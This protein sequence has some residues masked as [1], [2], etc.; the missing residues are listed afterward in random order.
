[1]Q[2]CI[3]AMCAH[4]RF[5]NST[6]LECSIA[7]QHCV[8]NNGCGSAHESSAGAVCGKVQQTCWDVN[9][10]KQERRWRL[11][12]LWLQAL[13]C[14]LYPCLSSTN[15]ITTFQP[16]VDKPTHCRG[17]LWGTHT[18]AHCFVWR[19]SFLPHFRI[20]CFFPAMTFILFCSFIRGEWSAYHGRPQLQERPQTA[21]AHEG[22]L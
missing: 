12:Q 20:K 16:A 5:V 10:L 3:Y 15:V 13:W 19:V 17:F 18:L 9:V 1:M 6:M 4:C 14:F 22:S 21:G 7:V 11:L 8:C 2:T